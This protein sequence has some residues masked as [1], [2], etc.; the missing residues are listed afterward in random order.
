[1]STQ[2]NLIFLMPDQLRPDFL[3]CYGAG[4]L[5]TPN[6]DRLSREGHRYT[7]CY[8]EHPLCVPARAALLTG[9]HG[10]KTGVLDN[11]QFLR[12]DHREMGL[13]TWPE[14]LNAAGYYTAAIGKM[15]FYPWDAR[16][17]FQ[18]R[19]IA[20]DKRWIHIRDDYYHHLRDHGHRKYHGNE[21]SGY[22]EDKGAVLNLLPWEHTIDH[23]VGQE[24]CRF[25]DRYS[26]DA[27]FAMMVGFPGPHCPYDPTREF[28]DKLNPEAMPPAVPPTRAGETL[29]QHNVAGNR[30]AWNGVDY[31]E[32]TPKQ[33]QKVRTHYAGLVQQ[34]DYE[35]GQILITLERSGLLDNTVIIFSADH[36]DYLG[37]HGMIG[38]GTFFESSI[39]VPMILRVPGAA[40]ETTHDDLVTLTDVT[41][42]LLTLAGCG[43]PSYMD[44]RPLPALAQEEPHES[45][46]ADLPAASHREARR[47]IVGA[48]Q[49]GWWIDDGTWRLCKYSTGDAFLFNLLE[50]PDEQHNRY[51]DAECQSVRERLDAVLTQTVMDY[52]AAAHFDHRVYISD[53]SQQSTFGR[54]GW[55]R[56]F[57]RHIDD[58][59]ARRQRKE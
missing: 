23:F 9:L 3:G 11:G 41:A 5:Q 26:S 49:G 35:V 44:S 17:G 34:I 55:Q 32:F 27:P 59:Q 15:H 16:M 2:P 42:T 1:M 24:A 58:P 39:H 25:I 20:E 22:F 51:R 37:D 40:G 4:F 13:H 6:I 10:L 36:G 52:T 45:V 29:R 54:E 50:D 18:Y 12:P 8:S 33:V 38:K 43:V 14:M 31:D 57:P 48:T 53:L 28:L 21:H 7:R 30:G 47:H 56:P 19:S 46:R